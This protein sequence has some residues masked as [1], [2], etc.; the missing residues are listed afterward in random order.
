MTPFFKAAM[1]VIAII[2]VLIAAS[3]ASAEVK[4]TPYFELGIGHRLNISDPMII[5]NPQFGTTKGEINFGAELDTRKA[6]W[7]V[8]FLGADRVD[9]GYF[10][11]SNVF[12][13]KPFNSKPEVSEEVIGA[14]FRWV[15]DSFSFTIGD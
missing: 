13:G 12:L 11:D 3:K 5:E 7:P 2:Y 10:H 9:I 1:A 8:L 15:F 14:R 4:I 6:G